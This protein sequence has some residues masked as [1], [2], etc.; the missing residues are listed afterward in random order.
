MNHGSTLRRNASVVVCLSMIVHFF[1]PQRRRELRDK[2]DFG[3]ALLK[4]FGIQ[5]FSVFKPL[6]T[7]SSLRLCG[8]KRNSHDFSNCL[9]NPIQSSFL[10]LVFC[11]ILPGRLHAQAMDTWEQQAN[12]QIDQLRRRNLQVI[13]L[14]QAQ[15]PVPGATVKIQQRRHDMPLGLAAGSDQLPLDLLHNQPLAAPLYRVFNSVNLGDTGR[16]DHIEPEMGLGDWGKLRYWL[17]WAHDMGLTVRFGSVFSA[18]SD[19]Q[20]DWVALQ[21]RRDLMASIELHQ[22][23]IL[24]R[25]ANRV[26]GFDLYSHALGNRFI[27]Q[28]LS[29]VMLRRMFEQASATA[30][31]VPMAIQMDDVLDPQRVQEAVSRMSELKAAFV[32]VNQWSVRLHVPADVDPR[33][34]KSGL[35]WLSSLKLPIVVSDL[36]FASRCDARAIR[37]AL[38]VLY[39]HPAVTGL[40]FGLTSAAELDAQVTAPLVDEQG[41]PTAAGREIDELFTQ[42]WTSQGTLQTTELGSVQTRVFCGLYDLVA[43]LPDGKVAYTSVYVSPDDQQPQGQKV[44]VLSP[45]A[46]SLEPMR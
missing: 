1:L 29:T 12:A 10:L 34:L 3:T 39:G 6:L 40:Y 17:D 38:S 31:R 44:V 15:Q 13:V 30:P 16:W 26:I 27:E 18:N 23:Q 19:H 32:P 9:S 22:R 8:K 37:T 5:S 36:T 14:D 43:T 24:G 25:Y 21:G 11:L 2:R 4:Q 46:V 41:K 42:V 20:A 33:R 45:L 35:D 7:L 28:Q